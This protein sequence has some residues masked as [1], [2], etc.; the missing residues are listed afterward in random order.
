MLHDMIRSMCLS[1]NFKDVFSIICNHSFCLVDNFSQ[2]NLPKIGQNFF[3]NLANLLYTLDQKESVVAS[4]YSVSLTAFCIAASR[5]LNPYL[6]I[7]LDKL[8][9]KLR[10][11][12]W[13]ELP[14]GCLANPGLLDITKMSVL[15]KWNINDGLD[16]WLGGSI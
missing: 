9:E 11:H 13:I 15:H 2:I 5:G 12:A 16:K 14:G 7:G 3:Q 6:V 1:M 4:C 10:G 8:D